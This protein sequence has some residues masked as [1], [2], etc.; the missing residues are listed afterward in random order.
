MYIYFNRN[1]E[2]YEAILL[3]AHGKHFLTIVYRQHTLT[4][5]LSYLTFKPLGNSHL[6][7]AKSK[8]NEAIKTM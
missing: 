3:K 6:L 1:K 8:F 4:G 7:N 2:K 5:R